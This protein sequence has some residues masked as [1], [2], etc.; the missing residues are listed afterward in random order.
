MS[1]SKST[2]LARLVE[3]AERR[4]DAVASSWRAE[5]SERVGVGGRIDVW[6]YDTLMLRLERW[7]TGWYARPISEGWGSISDK[8]GVGKILVGC[9]ALNARSYRELYGE[10]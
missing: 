7:T 2:N 6:H 5:R 4:G 9:R 10:V 3:V 1:E 8:Q